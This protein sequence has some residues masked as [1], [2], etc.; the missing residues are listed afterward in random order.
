MRANAEAIMS[1]PRLRIQSTVSKVFKVALPL[2]EMPGQYMEGLAIWLKADP[3]DTVRGRT[4]DLT[5]GG[6]SVRDPFVR[7]VATCGMILCDGTQ[8]AHAKDGLRDKQWKF[9]TIGS[10][11]LWLCAMLF[12]ALYHARPE[13]REGREESELAKPNKELKTKLGDSI[14]SVGADE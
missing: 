5:I 14:W 9:R 7:L 3:I 12:H 6:L 11:S 2:K 8:A 4:W 13:V 10:H 1:V